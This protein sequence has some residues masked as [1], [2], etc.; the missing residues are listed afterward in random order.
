[1]NKL[2]SVNLWRKLFEFEQRQHIAYLGNDPDDKTHR[3]GV[4]EFTDDPQAIWV[5]VDKHLTQWA[6]HSRVPTIVSCPFSVDGLKYGTLLY[7]HEDHHRWVVRE[8]KGTS[9]HTT[10]D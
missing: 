2:T 8:I 6:Y 4:S 7:L 9:T 1:M 10:I 5:M 3:K